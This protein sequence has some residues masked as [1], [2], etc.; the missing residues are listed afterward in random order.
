[1]S[2]DFYCEE[3]GPPPV[4]DVAAGEVGAALSA[5]LLEVIPPHAPPPP[6]LAQSPTNLSTLDSS[7]VF[8]GSLND[9]IALLVIDM[10]EQF[11]SVAAPLL[12]KLLPLIRHCQSTDHCETALVIFT[13]HGHERDASEEED[14]EMGRFW[15]REN[16]IR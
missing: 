16:I 7:V 9:R 5:P 15:G 1:M 2:I 14:G 3:K 8:N 11:R 12:P 4:R 6:H 13:Q 10:Q